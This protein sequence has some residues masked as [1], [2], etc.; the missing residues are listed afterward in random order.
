MVRQ[1]VL[2]QCGINF[3]SEALARANIPNAIFTGV[4]FPVTPP[5]SNRPSTSGTRPN[6]AV[7]QTQLQ[8]ENP[9][10]LVVPGS[11]DAVNS[12]NLSAKDSA[13]EPISAA[14]TDPNPFASPTVKP[15]DLPFENS[16]SSGVGNNGKDG[17]GSHTLFAG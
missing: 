7:R 9:L 10:K 5:G 4:G 12:I 3:D 14:T 1:V 16:S 2:S 15:A 13:K 8:A 17:N 11:P 6:S